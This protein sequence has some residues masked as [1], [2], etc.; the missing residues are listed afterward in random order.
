MAD[1]KNNSNEDVNTVDDNEPAAVT[2]PEQVAEL[3]ALQAQLSEA[4]GKA[5][6]YLDALQR[7]RADFTNYRRRTD[8]GDN[9]K[10]RPFR[11]AGIPGGWRGVV[12]GSPPHLRL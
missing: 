5:Q 11:G 9:D 12:W 10:R 3:E 2:E 1:K 6:E 8:L 4:Q 7:E